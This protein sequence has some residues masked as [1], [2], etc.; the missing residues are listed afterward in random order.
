MFFYSP[1]KPRNSNLD[2][3][4]TKTEISLVTNSPSKVNLQHNTISAN[5]KNE[6]PVTSES[7]ENPEELDVFSTG[8]AQCSTSKLYTASKQ[9]LPPECLEFCDIS[10]AN[11]TLNNV[12]L[13][14]KSIQ[15]VKNNSTNNLVSSLEHL[16]NLKIDKCNFSKTQD[17]ST[18]HSVKKLI[19]TIT[20]DTLHKKDNLFSENIISLSSVGADPEEQAPAYVCTVSDDFAN[21]F[22]ISEP[23]EKVDLVPWN[24]ENQSLKNSKNS[25]EARGFFGLGF[26]GN[27]QLEN[28]K[29]KNSNTIQA[30]TSNVQSIKM[31][32]GQ[33]SIYNSNAPSVLDNDK[34]DSTKFSVADKLEKCMVSSKTQQIISLHDSI[35]LNIQKISQSSSSDNFDN[36]N[37]KQ[38]SLFTHKNSNQKYETLNTEEITEVIPSILNITQ[39]HVSQAD[40]K[41]LENSSNFKWFWWTSSTNSTNKNSNTLETDFLI[42]SK[43]SSVSNHTPLLNPLTNTNLNKDIRPH[44][45]N[46]FDINNSFNIQTN[47]QDVYSQQCSIS[48][49]ECAGEK[50]DTSINSFSNN[51]ELFDCIDDNKNN[52][53]IASNNSTKH[54]PI[55]G[56]SKTIS[57]LEN[58]PYS[59]TKDVSTWTSSASYSIT[60]SGILYKTQ[61]DRSTNEKKYSVPGTKNPTLCKSSSIVE[62]K[63]GFDEVYGYSNNSCSSSIEGMKPGLI[64]YINSSLKYFY[65]SYFKSENENIYNSNLYPTATSSNIDSSANGHTPLCLNKIPDSY[66]LDA[67]NSIH[68]SAISVK[69]IVII[70]VHGW[71]PT[72]LLQMVAGE[73]TGTSEKFCD[74][75]KAS[76]LEYLFKEHGV[77]FDEND[78]VL[79]PLVAQGTVEDRVEVSLAQLID[80]NEDSDD[81]ESSVDIFT[82]NDD[83]KLNNS[84]FNVDESNSNT[85]ILNGPAK[86]LAREKNSD[87]LSRTNQNSN[88]K[89]YLE[90][91]LKNSE[92]LP[93]DASVPKKKNRRK[94]IEAADTVII[95][96]H[97]QGTPVSALLLERLIELNIVK[98][99]HQRVGMLAMAGINHGPFPAFRDN[100]I[101]KYVEHDAAR[102]LFFFT[103][104]SSSIVTQYIA[105]VGALL[106]KGVRLLYVASWVDEVVPFYSALLH[107]VSHPNIYRAVCIAHPLKPSFLTNLAIFAIKLKN[108]G[109][110]DFGLSVHLSE[111]IAGSIWSGS[112]SGHSTIYEESEVYKLLLRWMFFSCS[113]MPPYVNLQQ[114][115]S[116]P[117]ISFNPKN[118]L[119]K[120]FGKTKIETINSSEFSNEGST[121]NVNSDRLQ[122]CNSEFYDENAHSYISFTSQCLPYYSRSKQFIKKTASYFRNST[123]LAGFCG[124]VLKKVDL[125]HVFSWQNSPSDNVLETREETNPFLS[126]GRKT[127]YGSI[128]QNP[129]IVYHPFNPNDQLNPYFLPWIIKTIWES[130]AVNSNPALVEDMKS[131]VQQYDEWIPESKV[132]KELKYKL[133]PIRNFY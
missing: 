54:K 73:P 114:P 118:S 44:T 74:K 29:I 88:T 63:L 31:D 50:L 103:D 70:G 125:C 46:N 89:K 40:E 94:L 79:M 26:W 17:I 71:F 58:V 18:E 56:S 72:K 120:T 3:H 45:K 101:V 69:K 112:V 23:I 13:N 124:F 92:L 86:S 20:D 5:T 128:S 96:T 47:T 53:Q 84:N 59:D 78:I 36:N 33:N 60:D 116:L 21:S 15:L 115:Y 91:I 32:L 106:Q 90:N 121:S 9:H 126:K 48:I 38:P 119:L 14:S 93:I 2:T 42:N 85:S 77:D 24:T 61:E 7:H 117:I 57:L 104:P 107:A 55:K 51:T 95:V 76:V 11:S 105:A 97:S 6:Q 22:Q 113:S 34:Y 99:R 66:K 62:P 108:S 102:E 28:I 132:E 39:R 30:S 37:Q 19:N 111:A 109:I 49:S 122:N 98:P 127:Y 68:N 100:V 82:D 87:P 52:I 133:E 10:Q 43:N 8:K 25:S 80:F 64:N 81:E 130:T 4:N 65:S 67:E 41:I 27:Q 12:S 35:S 75:M 123:F 131:L 16:K 129:H 1:S 110:G 83:S